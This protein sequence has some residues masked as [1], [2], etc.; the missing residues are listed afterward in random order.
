MRDEHS[1]AWEANMKAAFDNVVTH[2]ANVNSITVQCLQNAV[3][4]ANL[5]GKLGINNLA[6]AVDRQWNVDEVANLTAKLGIQ[7]DAL[8]DLIIIRM[9]DLLSESG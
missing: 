4:N 2:Q 3:E 8:A 7:A 5:V 1:R 6:L 9:A